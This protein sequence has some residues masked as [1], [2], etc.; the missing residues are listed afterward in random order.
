MRVVRRREEDAQRLDPPA[1]SRF[2]LQSSLEQKHTSP[3][4]KINRCLLIWDS[5][6][7]QDIRRLG[8]AKLI[9]IV[10]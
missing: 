3:L 1:V 8:S 7:R 4:C 2:K 10:H 5:R 6:Q 9:I